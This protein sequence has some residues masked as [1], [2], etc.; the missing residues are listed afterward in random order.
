MLSFDL[1]LPRI[2]VKGVCHTDDATDVDILKVLLADLTD[3]THEPKVEHQVDSFVRLTYSIVPAA[4][5]T[6]DAP[7]P[8]RIGPASKTKKH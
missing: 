5:V 4:P 1:H 8:K 3:S 6:E 7:K 2:T